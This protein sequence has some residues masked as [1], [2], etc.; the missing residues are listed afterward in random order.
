MLWL[1]LIVLLIWWAAIRFLRGL[2][3]A[4]IRAD[5]L[6]RDWYEF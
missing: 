1:A 3:A 2:G 6:W 4:F 5:E